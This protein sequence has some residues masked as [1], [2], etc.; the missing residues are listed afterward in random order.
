VDVF[1]LGIISDEISDDFERAC[2]LLRSW[3][4]DRVEL[5][6][7]WGRDILELE[8]AALARAHD[9]VSGHGLT[10]TAITAPVFESS[11][12]GGPPDLAADPELAAAPGPEGGCRSDRFEEQLGLLRR[13]CE[14]AEAFG[15]RTVRVA[16][17]LTHE[18]WDARVATA[19]AVKL[20]AAAEIARASGALLVVE[21][22]PSCAADSGRRLAALDAAVREQ[23]GDLAGTLALLWDVGN[24]VLAGEHDAYPN[25]YG[26]LDP[27]RVAHVHL[28]DVALGMGEP[29][30]VPVGHGGIDLRGQLRALIADGY[31]GPLVLEPH[32][33]RVE[34]AEREEVARGAVEAARAF[35][36]GVPRP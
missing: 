22:E 19:I 8:P 28:K 12:A 34:G 2:A 24:A 1:E 25:G 14:I 21:N 36:A 4:L 11:L 6:T 10:V 23:A 30:V 13:A 31:T 17:F 16:S 26:A 29:R 9:V 7:L 32:G 27:K 35:L 5:R 20:A 18:P 3:E 33:A 15:T